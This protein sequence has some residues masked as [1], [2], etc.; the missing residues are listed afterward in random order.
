MFTSEMYIYNSELVVM[1]LNKEALVLEGPNARPT[2]SLSACCNLKT[3][4][5]YIDV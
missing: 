1:V 2:C 5:I 4:Y 3:Y